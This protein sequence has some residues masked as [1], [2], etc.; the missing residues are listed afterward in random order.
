VSDAPVDVLLGRSEDLAKGWLLTLLEQAPLDDAPAILAAD[1]ARDG[2]RVCDA[3]VRALADDVDLHRLEAGG[4]FEP[5]VARIGE[6]AG[7]SGAPATSRAVDA[8]RSIVWSALR[9]ALPYPDPD[10]LSELSERL[11]LVT[12]TIREAALRRS[13]AGFEA[14]SGHDAPPA[15]RGLGRLT[16]ARETAAPA[17]AEPLR[18]AGAPSSAESDALWLGALDDE[19]AGAT[20]AG[21]PLALLLAELG[22]ADRVLVVEPTAEASATFGRFAQAVRRGLRRQ[23]ILACE[24]ES[25]AWII[26]RDTG[27]IGAQAL[28]ARIARAVR[29]IDPWRGA[30]LIVSIGMA[31]LGEDGNDA[32]SLIE[33]A[34][35]ATFAAAASGIEVARGEG[36]DGEGH[37]DGPSGSTPGSQGPGLA[38]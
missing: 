10:Q 32:A 25:R 24:T 23:D 17:T 27:R 21:S 20:R 8:L 37:G 22:D 9:E 3:V 12:E 29:E 2:P 28:G 14:G 26:A 33:A 35:E 18:R 5:L 7:A 31:V 38:S 16:P 11:A 36:G 6:L 4:A 13:E 34:E 1:L 30:P 15:A 19:I